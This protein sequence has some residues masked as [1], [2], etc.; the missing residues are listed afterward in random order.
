M[1]PPNSP[2]AAIALAAVSAA[3]ALQLFI[4]KHLDKMGLHTYFYR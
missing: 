4:L 2:P 1:K 3:S